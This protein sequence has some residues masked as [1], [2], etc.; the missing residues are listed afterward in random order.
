M[1]SGS[2]LFLAP[3]IPWPCGTGWEQRAFAFLEH[4]ARRFEVELWIISEGQLPDAEQTR[5]LRTL[6]SSFRLETPSACQPGGPANPALLATAS[7]ASWIHAM[8][9]LMGL[10]PGDLTARLLWD[11]DEVPWNLRTSRPGQSAVPLV[12]EADPLGFREWVDRAHRVM[13]CSPLELEPGLLGAKGFLAPNVVA[14]PGF[15]PTPPEARTLLLAGNWGFPPNMDGLDLFL[16]AI[17]PVLRAKAPSIQ[18][19]LAGRSPVYPPHRAWLA[20]VVGLCRLEYLADCP[21]MDAAYADAALALAPLR[22]GGGTRIKLLEAFAR[23]CCSVS[24]AVGCE[25]LAVQDGEHLRVRDDPVAFAEACLELLAS[26]GQRRALAS[27]ARSFF[28][29]HH[30]QAALDA[31][32]AGIWEAGS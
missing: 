18:V 31:A 26:P 8:R 17:L 16:T 7:R 32:M 30:S 14:D 19:R 12:R 11:L 28:E 21:T 29:T 24:T 1:P 23:G 4:Y 3:C 2:L 27:R 20:R 5:R 15:A 13:V 25:G 22:L 6:V 9:H 10:L